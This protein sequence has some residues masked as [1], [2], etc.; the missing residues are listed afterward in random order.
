M[1]CSCAETIKNKNALD[2]DTRQHSSMPR[3]HWTYLPLCNAIIS[4]NIQLKIRDCSSLTERRNCETEH[5]NRCHVNFHFYENR[6]AGIYGNSALEHS[7]LRLSRQS[8]VRRFL[9]SR[10]RFP[11]SGSLPRLY[12]HKKSHTRPPASRPAPPPHRAPAARTRRAV[13]EERK[14]ESK[15]EANGRPVRDDG[16]LSVC[17]SRWILRQK[18]CKDE[19]ALGKRRADARRDAHL[20]L[21][22]IARLAGT[23]GKVK[24]LLADLTLSL[25]YQTPKSLDPLGRTATK[26]PT[27]V[28]EVLFAKIWN[29]LK[30]S[31][32]RRPG[33]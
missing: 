22:K 3:V 14:S 26:V 24:N 19:L 30:D 18:T 23:P 9:S 21:L 6:R 4:N 5:R 25:T 17:Q 11:G 33:E 32:L 1:F 13:A 27:G 2:T 12:P 16:R 15:V 8:V 29:D 10:P 20:V 31:N 28:L 7:K